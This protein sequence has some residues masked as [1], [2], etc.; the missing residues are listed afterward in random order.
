M[1]IKW[2]LLGIPFVLMA[3]KLGPMLL[4]VNP[5]ATPT[6]TATAAEPPTLAPA[7]TETPSPFPTFAP[8]S[9]QVPPPTAI[10]CPKG[11]DLNRSTNT[12][13]YATRTLDPDSIICTDYAGKAGCI[14]HGCSWDAKS[15][16]CK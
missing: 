12:C 7:S 6:P 4:G 1:K 5:T 9:T 10:T 11:T 2:L 13:F 16:S 8:I 15:G 3:C 14:N